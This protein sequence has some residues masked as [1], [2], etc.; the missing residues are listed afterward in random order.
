M[1]YIGIYLYLFFL[2][3]G[4]K[5]FGVVDTSILANVV[6]LYFLGNVNLKI[7]SFVS[8]LILWMMTI[9][10]YYMGVAIYYDSVDIVFLG[11]LIRSLCSVLCIYGF[12]CYFARDSIEDKLNWLSNALVVHAIIVILSATIF[13]ELQSYLS[14][15]SD[16]YKRPRILR[17]T[18]LMAGFD[19]AG[20]I[21]NI[22]V[23]LVLIKEKFSYL[24]FLIFVTAVLFTSRFSIIT[25]FCILMLFLFLLRKETGKSKLFFISVPLFVVGVVGFFLLALTTSGIVS[26]ANVSLANV[27]ISDEIS[28]AYSQ[29]DLHETTKT[30]LIFF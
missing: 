5:L 20:L 26:D 11:R 22:G 1:K 6:A 19:I 9:V 17:S 25:L 15:I 10:L 4:P 13:V 30:Q 24:K 12:S 16:Y 7:D 23:V 3:Y 2:L 21:C 14:V 28:W 18:G 29:T 8:S 27:K